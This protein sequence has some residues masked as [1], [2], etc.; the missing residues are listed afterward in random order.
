MPAWAELIWWRFTI[1]AAFVV[2]VLAT[3]ML[4]TMGTA[5]ELEGGSSADEP[6]QLARHVLE[7]LGPVPMKQMNTNGMLVRA[8]VACAVLLKGRMPS[9]QDAGLCLHMA[10]WGAAS[11]HLATWINS[12][13]SSPLAEPDRLSNAGRTMTPRYIHTCHTAYV[14]RV[15]TL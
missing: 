10:R 7:V 8:A 2:L 9:L 6:D 11:G 15:D 12:S 1:F 13:L 5:I 4:H 14:L 3:L